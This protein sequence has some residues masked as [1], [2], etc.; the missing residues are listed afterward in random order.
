MAEPRSVLLAGSK[1]V[2]SLDDL[3]S[4]DEALGAHAAQLSP[5][6]VCIATTQVS[7]AREVEVQADPNALA[8]FPPETKTVVE[9]VPHQ[10]V[11]IFTS[12]KPC[13]E[14]E[15]AP[16]ETLSEVATDDDYV[17]VVSKGLWVDIQNGRSNPGDAS[18]APQVA[19]A[20]RKDDRG[21]V[22]LVDGVNDLSRSDTAESLV[23]KGAASQIVHFPFSDANRMEAFT[24]ASWME[25]AGENVRRQ[26][27]YLEFVGVPP[28][29]LSNGL[30]N[31]IGV[32]HGCQPTL[33]HPLESMGIVWEKAFGDGCGLQGSG[34][35]LIDL[36]EAKASG[37]EARYLALRAKLPPELATIVDQVNDPDFVANFAKEVGRSLPPEADGWI[38]QLKSPGGLLALLLTFVGVHEVSK[39]FDFNQAWRQRFGPPEHFWTTFKDF[40]NWRYRGGPPFGGAGS[41]A[42]RG[43]GPVVDAEYRETTPRDGAK[44][45]NGNGKTNGTPKGNGEAP[46]EGPPRQLGPKNGKPEAPTQSPRMVMQDSPSVWEA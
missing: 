6:S 28:K 19:I 17:F 42:G 11:A 22:V 31:L 12:E 9:S 25:I 24:Y 37:D 46:Q 36:A 7:V 16:G 20:R 10:T 29:R 35:S 13:A 33:W 32:G 41:G 1:P 15:A 5:H 45:T 27:P 21:V 4:Y 14:Q 18:H 38:Q 40:V 26:G 39:F 43:T 2:L 30:G 23:T 3:P 44:G 8:S 34:V